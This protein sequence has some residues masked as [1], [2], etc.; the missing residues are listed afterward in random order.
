MRE[1]GSTPR[2][3]PGGERDAEGPRGKGAAPLWRPPGRGSGQ[4]RALGG[5]PGGGV[6]GRGGA[7]S[8]E[9]SPEE[10]RGQ[11]QPPGGARR[12]P[13]RRGRRL[14]QRRGEVLGG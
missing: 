3:R 4:R 9:A 2:C 6:V 7:A 12:A 11:P 14:P 8:P 13:L 1:P 5:G 10:G